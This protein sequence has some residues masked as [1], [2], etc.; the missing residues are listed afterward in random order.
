MDES[1]G[2][3][4]KVPPPVPT[5][6][7]LRAR[8]GRALRDQNF[9]LLLEQL[10]GE[11][12]PAATPDHVVAFPRDRAE[13]APPRGPDDSPGKLISGRFSKR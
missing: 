9:W 7:E 4:P 2:G 12:A 13:E 6:E 3:R 1:N 11:A 8:F 5:M 10:E